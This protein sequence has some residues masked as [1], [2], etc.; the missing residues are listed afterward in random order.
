MAL[1]CSKALIQLCS[2][3]TLSTSE[4]NGVHSDAWVHGIL[5]VKDKQSP[6]S[7]W[8]SIK[9]PQTSRALNAPSGSPPL[10]LQSWSSGLPKQGPTARANFR[11]LRWIPAWSSMIWLRT[12]ASADCNA[13]PLVDTLHEGP[14]PRSSACA[15][16]V[17]VDFLTRWNKPDIYWRAP[18][19]EWI[20]HGTPR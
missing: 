11:W 20:P 1:F 12:H 19:Q 5:L 4:G 9:D 3:H 10:L 7:W 2:Q 6:S 14:D 18:G 8:S 13:L 16:S 17:E 15:L